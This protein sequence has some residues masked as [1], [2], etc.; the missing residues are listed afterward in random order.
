MLS[1]NGPCYRSQL[2]NDTLGNAVHNYTRPYRPRTNGK[3]ERF[4]HL[5]TF[6]WAYAGYYNSNAAR[7]AAYDAWVHSCNHHRPRTSIGGKSPIDREHD[8]SGKNT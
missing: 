1:D 2:F 6:E 7:A 5:L 3:I 4:H 8:V